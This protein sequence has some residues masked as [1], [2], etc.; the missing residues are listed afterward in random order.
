L[1]FFSNIKYLFF[2]RFSY[3]YH[4]LK[5]IRCLFDSHSSNE[6]NIVLLEKYSIPDYI[7]SNAIFIDY[8]T[9]NHSR[10]ARVF[11]PYMDEFSL[12]EKSI[13]KSFNLKRFLYVKSNLFHSIKSIKESFVLIFKSKNKDDIFNYKFQNISIGIDIYESY[14]RNNN[15][16]LKNKFL[17]LGTAFKA[18]VTFFFWEK[19]LQNN[20][21]K[22]LLLSHDYHYKRN[23]LAKLCYKNSI[24]VFLI[25]ARSFDMCTGEYQLY[26]SKF[27]RYSK[28]F[29]SL[30]KLERK[31]AIEWAENRISRRIAGDV[32][33][34]MSYSTKSAFVRSASYENSNFSKEK[35]N[36]LITSHDFVDNPH[37]YS[38]LPYVDFYEW[39]E[40]LGEISLNSKHNWFIKMHPDA[41]KISI[42][43]IENFVKKY[44]SI[45]LIDN[46]V[47]FH[48][49][50]QAGL[51]AV[52][53]C[54]G[55][56]GHELPLLGIKVINAAFNPHVS[57]NFNE[58]FDNKYEYKRFIQN[59]SK[60]H[61]TS[62]NKNHHR[63]ICKFFYM[64]YKYY[65]KDDLVYPSFKDSLVSNN[66]L[67]LKRYI[68]FINH[69]NRLEL[70]KIQS[71]M[72]NLYLDY[73]GNP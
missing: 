34:E 35:V 24:R 47:S 49:L 61:C 54:Y 7:I 50:K 33:I 27:E 31:K 11:I 72:A 20:N 36:I 66:E 41:S 37:A 55:S 21:V 6:D 12:L 10:S 3:I 9:R 60:E 70:K 48:D 4:A 29:N 5:K 42:K 68:Y 28:V 69:V 39:L 53:T 17:I 2:H 38:K 23:I 57:F 14:I 67:S 15:P 45:I 43:T 26:K 46:N 65:S 51:D 18:F 63:E 71:K 22:E 64:H 1:I 25:T 13:F 44:P 59:L 32:G 16:T 8:L 19:Y 30:G 56:V 52:T 40:F 58:H 62:S 73:I